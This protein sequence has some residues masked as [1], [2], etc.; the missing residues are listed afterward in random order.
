[1]LTLIGG[2]AILA[3]CISS[4]GLFGMVVFATE[5]RIK[6]VSVRK[7]MGA[8][9]WM[10]VYLMGKGFLALLVIA[11]VIAIPLTYLFFKE[12]ALPE[13]VNPAPIGFIDLFGGL[14]AILVIALAMIGSQTFKV[15][16]ANPAEVLR[17]E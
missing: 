13:L 2:L 15:A 17:A 5:S 7:V 1:M 3:I 9:E 16:R 12:V 10:L 8:P 6:E 4:L 11:A 14:I